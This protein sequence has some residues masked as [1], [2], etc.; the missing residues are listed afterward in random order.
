MSGV[1]PRLLV[2]DDT[3]ANLL[4]LGR[5]LAGEFD[6]QIATSG[7]MGLALATENPP[8]LILLDIMMPEMDGYET[9]QRLK[10]MPQ[11]HDIPLV[12][13]TA[14]ADTEA[15]SAGLALGAADFITKP[16][17]VAVARQ[18]IFNLL[19][20]EELRREV[21]T[22]RDHLEELVAA[23]TEALSIAKEAAETANRAKSTFLANMSHELRTPLNGIMGLT[24]LVLRR[25]T[26]PKLRDQ[27]GKIEMASHDLLAIIN[28]ILDISKIEAERLTLEQADFR[29][30]EILENIRSLMKPKATEKGLSLDI[31][32]SPELAALIVR[33]D[34]LRLGQVLLNLVG[35]AIK[36]TAE[37]S[38]TLHARIEDRRQDKVSLRLEVTDTGIGITPI[39]QTRLFTAFEQADGSMTRKYGGTGLGLAI[40]KRLI[41]LMD[42]QIGVS[43]TPGQGSTFWLTVCLPVLDHMP[44][45]PVEDEVSHEH[46]LKSRFAGRRILLAE[47]EPINQAVSMGLLE[48][49]GLKVD[50]AEDGCEAERMAQ[51]TDYAAILMDM[52][53]PCMDGLV[54]TA[55]IRKIPG[56]ER[57]PILALTANTFEETRAR[58]LEAGMN[59]FIAKPVRPEILFATLLKWLSRAN[60]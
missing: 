26:D 47:D 45:R 17:N 37:G 31:D 46:H 33:G 22:Q 40:S 13:I 35:N 36:F 19:D 14:L 39:D 3:P 11:L 48:E 6:L 42:G 32:I 51:L 56:R 58:C 55:A 4:T 28:D 16:F 41:R 20:R 8:D 60:T 7:A 1:R 29:L 57:T 59:D 54:A 23:R 52:Q 44:A 30:G 27:L 34:P 49:V 10:A 9:C 50:L 24:G 53:M 2:I 43:S 21:E 25:V 38:I 15:E 12:F 5:A 18:R